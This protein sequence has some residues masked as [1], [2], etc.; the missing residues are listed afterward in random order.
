METCKEIKFLQAHADAANR[1]NSSSSRMPEDK[2]GNSGKGKGGG[3]GL[4]LH[5]LE[6]SVV[7][8]QQQPQSA[9]P[10]ACRRARL[11][12]KVTFPMQAKVKAK[13]KVARGKTG[14]AAYPSLE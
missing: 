8:T 14:N 12:N 7:A 11:A 1:H 3:K 2:K 4:F 10:T 5:H 6:P 13:A 9:S